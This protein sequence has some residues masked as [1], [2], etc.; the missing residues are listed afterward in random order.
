VSRAEELKRSVETAETLLS[1]AG[2]MKALS[3][4]RIRRFREGTQAARE[5]RRTLELGL[6]VALKL[7]PKAT[8]P[9]EE[10]IRSDERAEGGGTGA[11]VFGSDLGLAGQFNARVADH[12]LQHLRVAGCTDCQ[13][14]VLAVGA[15]VASLLE[16]AGLGVEEVLPVPE[17]T[18][19]VT[20]AARDIVLRLG[21]W[22]TGRKCA[23]LL[24]FHNEYLTGASYG[25]RTVRLLPLDRV[26]LGEVRR[27][28]WPT[29]VIP[30]TPTPW[31]ELLA[32]LT[33]EYMFALVVGALSDSLASEHASRLAAMEVAEQ[34]VDERL[35]DLRGRQRRELQARITEELLELTVGYEASKADERR[36]GLSPEPSR[37]AP[38]PPSSAEGKSRPG[39]PPSPGPRGG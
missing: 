18:G 8:E 39:S 22:R 27:R 38:R 30:M 5:Y 31:R 16:I 11:V 37:E 34:R 3:A 6:Q 9:H 25:P 35:A 13:P 23:T 12:A 14:P 1:V 4:A 21:A 19:A 29:R 36:G 10:R 20:S 17:S 2:S 33:R 26:W 15:R 28:P 7:V 24:L 32:H